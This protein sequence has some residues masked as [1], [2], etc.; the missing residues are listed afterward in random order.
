MNRRRDAE[1]RAAFEEIRYFES[2]ERRLAGLLEFRETQLKQVYNTKTFRYSHKLR[3]MYGR[4]RGL[5]PVSATNLPLPEH[6][7]PG[8]YQ[9]WIETFD[10]LDDESTGKITAQLAA[11]T[12]RPKISVIMPVYNPP[13]DMLREAIESVRGQLYEDWELCIADDCSTDVAVQQLLS[14]YDASDNRVKVLRRSENGHI[15]AASNSALSLVTGGWVALLDHDDLLAPHALALF[16][17]AINENPD[18]GV[19]YSDEDKFDE[20]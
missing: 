13:A 14:E 7:P 1:H 17:L 3:H 15:S 20:T 8:T 10:T 2:S 5:G 4:L 19:I 18:A 11:M 12:Q 6:L 16:A 9:T